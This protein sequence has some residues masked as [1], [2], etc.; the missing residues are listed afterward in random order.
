MI[1]FLHIIYEV[2]NYLSYLTS[3]KSITML[4][5]G[6][7]SNPLICHKLHQSDHTSQ[8]RDRI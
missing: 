4:E 6:K 5:P 7:W 8:M 3:Y 1:K 2:F